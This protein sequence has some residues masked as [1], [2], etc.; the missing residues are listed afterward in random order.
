VDNS[1]VRGNNTLAIDYF[2]DIGTPSRRLLDY[3]IAK[4]KRMRREDDEGDLSAD[5]QQ[6]GRELLYLYFLKEDEL[7]INKAE[8]TFADMANIAMGRITSNNAHMCVRNEKVTKAQYTK[9]LKKMEKY[10]LRENEAGKP[11]ED[12]QVGTEELEEMTQN[13]T[14]EA[15][16]EIRDDKNNIE[17][18][19]EE[20]NK[21]RKE[22]KLLEDKATTNSFSRSTFNNEVYSKLE[23]LLT[24]L[25]EMVT[26]KMTQKYSLAEI[27]Q[28]LN[29]IEG[30]N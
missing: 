29:E 13:H 7:K 15:E 26:D 30:T 20:I 27:G 28:H 25:Y 3:T 16:S 22:V 17:K 8:M 14:G 9:L 2:R 1:I 21:I 18:V 6:E 12:R 24:L 10:D 23:K 4:E 5:Y 11:K 19:I